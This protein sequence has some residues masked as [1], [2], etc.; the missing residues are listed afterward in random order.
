MAKATPM[1]YIIAYNAKQQN[2]TNYKDMHNLRVK[3]PYVY[4]S[5]D[6]RTAHMQ[7]KFFRYQLAH[8]LLT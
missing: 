8:P 3:N 6:V 1:P 4:R 2:I 5:A 7:P